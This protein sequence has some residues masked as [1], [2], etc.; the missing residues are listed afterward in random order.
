MSGLTTRASHR[1]PSDEPEKLMR[2]DAAD[3]FRSRV[4]W[5][6][7]GKLRFTKS[8]RVIGEQRR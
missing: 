2:F 3:E 8:H 4:A 7:P 1:S 6:E 5:N